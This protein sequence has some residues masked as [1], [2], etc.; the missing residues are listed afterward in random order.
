MAKNSEGFL[1]A[2]SGKIGTVVVSNWNGITVVRRKPRYNNKP[3][4]RQIIQRSRFKAASQACRRLGN[5]FEECFEP[6]PRKSKRSVAVGIVYQQAITGE[7]P[8]YAI[9]YSKVM[10]AKGSLKP[11]ENASVSLS[12]PGIL[13]FNWDLD[14]E[15]DMNN[16]TN[17]SIMVVFDAEQ[18]YACFLI[19]GDSR[20]KGMGEFDVSIL[21]GRT[22]HTW[23][24]FRSADG[25][26]KADSVYTGAITLE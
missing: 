14:P 24:S 23:L 17:R 3:T 25:L 11:A 13:K 6:V 12:A 15:L 16:R 1:G 22:V 18:E 2:I 4:E 19:D 21:K 26:Y 5:V 8:N 7:F 20:S 9:D 10:V